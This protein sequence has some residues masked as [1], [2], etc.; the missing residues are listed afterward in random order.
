MLPCLSPCLG[1]D[2]ALENKTFQPSYRYHRQS[3]ILREK[4]ISSMTCLGA[5]GSISNFCTNR[6]WK[7]IDRVSSWISIN[8][9]SEMR[10]LYRT[11]GKCFSHAAAKDRRKEHKANC[12]TGG[13]GSRQQGK[14]TSCQKTLILYIFIYLNI[15]IF[16]IIE[17][18]GLEGTFRGHLSQLPCNKEGHLQ[19]DQVA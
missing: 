8:T 9:I 3:N 1:L 13:T 14:T 12:S 5:K 11:T 2:H 17:C 16:R 7:S 18:F 4:Q 15:Y 6:S 19:Q 10:A